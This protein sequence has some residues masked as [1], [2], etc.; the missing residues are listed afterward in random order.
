MIGL[1]A[2][3]FMGWGLLVG[4]V[5]LGKL[6]RVDRAWTYGSLSAF[7][8]VCIYAIGYNTTDSY[9]YLLPACLIFSI[10][11]GVGLYEAMTE[12]QRFMPPNFNAARLL[13]LGLLFLPLLSLYLNFSRVNLSRDNE[14]LVY[15]Q[16]ILEAVELDAVIITDS[17]PYT[18][19]L[20]YGRYGLG[21]RPDV[22]IINHHLLAYTWYRQTL[23]HSH[24]HLLLPGQPLEI[25]PALVE[26]NIGVRPIYLAL[27]EPIKLNGYHLVSQ[28]PYLQRVVKLCE[29]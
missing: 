19:S 11:V 23:Q 14:A 4:L 8:L 7:L 18:F 1:L 6:F 2:E 5:G 9:I 17:D 21:L 12:V 29:Q 22:V 28:G 13:G 3:T 24:A 25:V 26:A 20:W 15:A 10:W 27:L 16:Q